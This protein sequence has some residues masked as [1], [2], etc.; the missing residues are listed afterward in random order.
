MGTR[1]NVDSALVKLMSL[2]DWRLSLQTHKL[3]GVE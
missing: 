1:V 2:G 3:L